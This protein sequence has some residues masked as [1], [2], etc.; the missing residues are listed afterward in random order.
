MGISPILK[1]AWGYAGR[2][3]KVLPDLIMGTKG[4]T[5]EELAEVIRKSYYTRG[6]SASGALGNGWAYLEKVSNSSG[7][8]VWGKVKQAA[9]EAKNVCISGFK[10]WKTNYKAGAKAAKTAGENTVLGGIKEAG[11]AF[12]K[13]LPFLNSILILATSVPNI[14]TAVKEKGIIQGVKETGK[15]IG[16]AAGFSA[17]MAVGSA[18]GAVAGPVGVLVG[19][20]LGGM[21]GSWLSGKVL[22]KT[23]TEQKEE[24]E[25]AV[26]EAAQQNPFQM[27]QNIPPME[28]QVPQAGMT[29][30]F[31][32]YQMT[33]S[34]L[35]VKYAND[36]MAPKFNAWA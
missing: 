6:R 19:G 10:N 15:A 3:G 27:Q 30:P 9:V 13:A 24:K 28:S 20:F 1:G 5:T 7:L 33:N 16:D 17:G 21:A 4:A 14:V 2:V 26:A 25:Q 31:M 18:I 23:Y 36:V 35:S 32:Q 29:N 22:G 12:G 34:P 8:S 11:R